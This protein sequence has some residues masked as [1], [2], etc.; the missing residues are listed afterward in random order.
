[1]SAIQL[2]TQDPD[3]EKRTPLGEIC[4]AQLQFLLD[5]LEDRV[6]GRHG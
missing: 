6:R 2:F 1:M 4:E 3:S 5:H